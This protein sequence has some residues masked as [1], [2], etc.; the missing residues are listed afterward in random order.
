MV[1][2]EHGHLSCIGITDAPPKG[3]TPTVA[4]IKAP[5]CG[6]RSGGRGYMKVAPW[7]KER[8]RPHLL[9]FM[10]L[11]AVGFGA[12]EPKR[13]KPPQQGRLLVTRP[14]RTD[15]ELVQSYVAQI[16]A[17]QHIEL[18]AL[19]Q[20]YVQKVFVDE[21]QSVVRDTTLFQIM[22]KLF[23]A[24]LEKVNAEAELTGIEYNNT[25]DLARKNVV[26]KNELALAKARVNKAKA[27]VSLA[28][29]RR[30]LTALKAPFDGMV[31]RF[32]VRT[33]SLVDEGDVLT[34]LSDTRSVWAYFNVSEAEYLKNKSQPEGERQT[35]VKLAMANGEI[36][37]QP[38]RIE[39]IEADFNN[40]TGSI[41]FRA[42]FA[43]PNK[44]LRHGETG[45]AL[46]SVPLKNVLLIPQKATFDVLD[47]KFVFV[48]DDKNVI[49]AREISVTAELAQ[50]F[51]VDAGIDEKE[52]ILVEGL[53]KVSEGSNIL[54]NFKSPEEVI[55]GLEVAA[56]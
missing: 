48:V 10:M 22:P 25:R 3:L 7:E 8:M 13:P 19:E 49:H 27:E 55:K 4:A 45:R 33:G 44:L 1:R 53:R 56:E 16:S 46:L 31:G 54:P 42:T 29:T 18:R 36:Y 21:G 38:G 2:T 39:T 15:T 26:S 47:K 41:A 37:D 20:G 11:A 32:L 52:N 30:E 40:A 34:T 28:Q 17:I 43:N 14:L 5:D 6:H 24:E 35:V 9:I 12:C 51:V 50:V 23:Q